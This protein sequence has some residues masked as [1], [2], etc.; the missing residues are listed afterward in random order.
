MMSFF[1][2]CSLFKGYAWVDAVFHI[3]QLNCNPV[4]KDVSLSLRCMC[5]YDSDE[6]NFKVIEN[7]HI[8]VI[9]THE[10]YVKKIDPEVL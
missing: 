4:D 6:W 10:N 3:F 7:F 9:C 2:K 8:I 1:Q 5:M